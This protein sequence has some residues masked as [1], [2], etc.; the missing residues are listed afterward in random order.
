MLLTMALCIWIRPAADDF[1]YSTL[2]DGG[3]QAFLKNNLEHYQNYT[4]RVFVHLVLYPLLCLDMWPLR[5]FVAILIGGCSVMAARLAYADRK[6]RTLAQVIALSAFWLMG[7]ETLQDGV[8]WG[9]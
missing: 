5:A 9:A 2:G 4:G 7:I 6:Q 3:W 1:Y 8:L